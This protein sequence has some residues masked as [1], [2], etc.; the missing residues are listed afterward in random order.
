MAEIP[1]IDGVPLDLTPAALV[2]IGDA[3]PLGCH[4]GILPGRHEVGEWITCPDCGGEREILNILPIHLAHDIKCVCPRTHPQL[5][6]V[7]AA[8][9]DSWPCAYRSHRQDLMDAHPARLYVSD[10]R[11]T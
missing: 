2:D 8:V 9:L 11:L 6:V 7:R 10:G 5:V 4:A 3:C 1:R